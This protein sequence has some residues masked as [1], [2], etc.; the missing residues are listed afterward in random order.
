MNIIIPKKEQSLTILNK[1]FK[2][3]Y[4]IVNS[5]LGNLEEYG[6]GVGYRF[7]HSIRVFRLV[8]FLLKSKEVKKAVAPYKKND[9]HLDEHLMIAALFHDI[10]RAVIAT[11]G[12]FIDYYHE[13]DAEHDLL[14]VE[15]IE[16]EL[17]NILPAKS[18]KIIEN[19]IINMQQIKAESPQQVLID[20]DEL[21]TLGLLKVYRMIK[22]STYLKKCLEDDI[23]HWWNHERFIVKKSIKRIKFPISKK[24][25]K[26]RF[27]RIDNFF[28]TIQKE[29]LIE[30]F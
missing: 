20:A 10:G 13:R 19:L 25:A 9:K 11:K 2:F 26:Q 12:K 4:N 23:N 15:I 6:G 16:K 18:L 14:A 22:Y 28:K 17:I 21:D 24:L 29:Q 5:Y 7:D 1:P 27:Q 3:Y 30:D 8:K